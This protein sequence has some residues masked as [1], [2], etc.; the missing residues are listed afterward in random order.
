[1]TLI[2]GGEV[3]LD[4]DETRECGVAGVEGAGPNCKVMRPTVLP[5]AAMQVSWSTVTRDEISVNDRRG[6]ADCFLKDHGLSSGAGGSGGR[7]ARDDLL[8]NLEGGP[9]QERVGR[10]SGVMQRDAREVVRTDRSNEVGSNV[11]RS[12]RFNTGKSRPSN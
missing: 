5:K 3:R 2:D 9:S 4:K 7:A 11:H 1:M 10:E 6:N 8:N 12:H